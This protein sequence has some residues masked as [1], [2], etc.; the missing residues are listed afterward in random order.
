MQ[1]GSTS[2]CRAMAWLYSKN[3]NTIHLSL[4]CSDSVL[5]LKFVYVPFL[6]SICVTVA[7][8]IPTV[9]FSR[10]L[11]SAAVVSATSVLVSI[12]AVFLTIVFFA[13]RA[14]SLED[15]YLLTM[16]MAVA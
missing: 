9:P 5:C 12:P 2:L 11:P 10:L 7:L 13:A 15:N 14:P 16:S 8:S 1:L 3:Q 4:V 6:N